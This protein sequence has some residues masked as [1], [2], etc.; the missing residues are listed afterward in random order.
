MSTLRERMRAG[1]NLVGTMVNIMS[2][3]DIPRILQSCGF[4]FFIIDC[5][6]GSFDYSQVASMVAVAKAIDLPVLVRIPGALREPVLRLMEMGA[7]GL[8]LPSTDTPELARKLV[9]YAKY[10]PM[11]KRGMSMMRAHNRY[12]P[13]PDPVAYMKQANEDTILVC[14]RDN[15][16]C[17]VKYISDVELMSSRV[18]LKK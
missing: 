13:V 5:E 9:E 7:D 10:A 8:M 18:K 11:G 16:D 14:R 17:I 12:I 2:H 6:H 15:E 1:E 4:D 3:P